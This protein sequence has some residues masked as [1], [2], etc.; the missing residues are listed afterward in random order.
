GV[1]DRDREADITRPSRTPTA[2]LAKPM[3]ARADLLGYGWILPNRGDH[4]QPAATGKLGRI[5]SGTELGTRPT[6]ENLDWKSNQIL[7]RQE[8]Q[9]SKSCAPHDD[10][11]SSSC[12]HR[13]GNLGLRA[14]NLQRPPD[15]A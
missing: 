6:L 13:R 10:E 15:N 14:S 12:A 5:R 4:A 9:D 11:V 7:G 1:A 2:C 3:A 8:A